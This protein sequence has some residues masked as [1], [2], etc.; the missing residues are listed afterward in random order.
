MDP[1]FTQITG[2]LNAGGL[3]ALSGVLFYL[4]TTA[5]KTF[6]EELK[7]ER[8][9]CHD[10]HEKIMANLQANHDLLLEVA[11]KRNHRASEGGA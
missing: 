8:E 5:L 6:R 1:T 9:Q 4:H 2:L 3:I 7:A 11:K 10:D